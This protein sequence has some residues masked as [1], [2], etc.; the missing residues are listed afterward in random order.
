MNETIETA[1]APRPASMSVQAMRHGSLIFVAGQSGVDPSTGELVGEQIREQA[2]RAIENIEAV[3][4]AAGTSLDNVVDT[5]C[6]LTDIADYEAFGEVYRAH[7]APARPPS[8]VFEARLP[9][10]GQLVAIRVVA[11]VPPRV[12]DGA[13][14]EPEARPDLVHAWPSIFV[15]DQ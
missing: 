15:D 3:L 11:S 4:S 5:V 9:I 7:F 14:T 12:H 13:A 2:H 8:T 10:S 6:I 1:S